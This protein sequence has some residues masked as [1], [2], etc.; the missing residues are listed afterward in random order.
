MQ[1]TP[2]EVNRFLSEWWTNIGGSLLWRILGVFILLLM[3][4]AL[5]R[6]ISGRAE[7]AMARSQMDVTL[8]MFFSRLI[9]YG[10]YALIIV[11][12]LAMLGVPMTS[13]IAIAS[14]S[15]LAIGLALQDSLK[16]IASGILIIFL[17]PYA[18]GDLVEINDRLGTVLEVG[19]YHTRLRTPDNKVMY[20]PNSNVMDENII[21][22][23]DLNI[24]RV[25]MVFGI[26][27]DDDMRQAKSVLR[28]ILDADGRILDDP[29]ARI[30]VGELG[31]NSVNILVQPFTLRENALD[32]R[33]DITE[34]V[35]LR[36]DEE[37][38]SFP[39]PQRDVHLFTAETAENG[40]S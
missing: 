28:A 7:K 25:D 5:I 22:L 6:F 26:G 15:V 9:R 8:S 16:N 40:H 21:N 3:A 11:I 37:G 4:H 39:Y 34:R 33:Y 13:V 36:F 18:V 29:P 10:L 24:L 2:D 1:V 35:K 38:I 14:A 12:A 31:D 27:Y 19:I 23:A 17:K 32:V 20:V 30:V